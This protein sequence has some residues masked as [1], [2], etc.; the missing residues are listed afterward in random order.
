MARKDR[1]NIAKLP[2]WAFQRC[3]NAHFARFWLGTIDP[4]QK[5]TKCER[6]L[7]KSTLAV[8]LEQEFLKIVRIMRADPVK[9]RVG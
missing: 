4:D 6:D 8:P 9:I 7:P 5:L 2:F 3:E 1:K